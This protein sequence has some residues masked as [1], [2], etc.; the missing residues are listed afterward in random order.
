MKSFIL[1]NGTMVKLGENCKENWQLI[2]DKKV[3]SNFYWFHLSSFPSGH[4]VL[5]SEV[6]NP[7]IMYECYL[8]CKIHSRQR[9]NNNLKVDCTQIKNL[10]KTENIGEVE[11]KSNKKVK[12]LKFS[13]RTFGTSPKLTENKSNF[14]RNEGKRYQKLRIPAM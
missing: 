5:F 9:N 10:K 11:Y 3:K 1:K 13:N 7:E 14:Q 4:L 2:S 6:I 12:V 8:I